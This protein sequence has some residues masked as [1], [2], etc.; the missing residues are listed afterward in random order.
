VG[1]VG[2]TLGIIFGKVF[3]RWAWPIGLFIEFMIS[4]SANA[5]CRQL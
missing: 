3:C 4:I 2:S 1:F 5:R